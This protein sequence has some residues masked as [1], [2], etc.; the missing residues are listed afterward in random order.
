MAE[1]YSD[2]TGAESGGDEQ[3]AKQAAAEAVAL[4]GA[5]G[6]EN[7]QPGDSSEE[8]EEEEM[9]A[10]L[11]E[12]RSGYEEDEEKKA[13]QLTVSARKKIAKYDQI[14][15]EGSATGTFLT[16]LFLTFLKEGADWAL[17][18][19]LVGEIPLLGQM[20]GWFITAIIIF[21]QWGRG[22][23]L[24][25]QIMKRGV[26]LWLDN[27]PVINNLP[28]SII[29][30]LWLWHYCKKEAEKAKEQKERLV[31]NTQEGL[32]MLGEEAVTA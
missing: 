19:I 8:L 14:I 24:R 12:D 5:E 1:E 9:L 10:E 28:L 23:F 21:L 26:L 6:A 30:T 31:R 25:N 29:Y 18:L 27:L 22:K 15:K 17:D 16:I 13:E 4:A 20:P 7:E 32:D 3:A 11:E 2:I